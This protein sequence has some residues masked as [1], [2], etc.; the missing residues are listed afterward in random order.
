MEFKQWLILLEKAERTSAKVPLYPPQYHTKQYTPLY[1][2][3]YTADYVTWLHLKTKPFTYTDFEQAFG[4]E[5]VPKPTWPVY[6]HDTP[7]HKH[8]ITDKF[9]WNIPS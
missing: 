7:A 4:D 2:A 1:H 8:T 3:P 6:N 9:K 5:K